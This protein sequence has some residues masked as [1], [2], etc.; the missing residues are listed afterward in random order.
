MYEVLARLKW[1]VRWGL[2]GSGA[3]KLDH[4]IIGS[5]DFSNNYVHFQTNTLGKGMK[6]FIPKLWVS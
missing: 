3:N 6:S 4:Y 2:H 1:L 5:S